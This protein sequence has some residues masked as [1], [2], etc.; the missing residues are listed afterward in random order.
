MIGK[1]LDRK[2]AK[3][4][5]I[6]K[7]SEKQRVAYNIISKDYDWVQ[8]KSFIGKL[9]FHNYRQVKKKL[10]NGSLLDIGTGNGDF[11]KIRGITN[12]PIKAFDVSDKMIEMAKKNIK[13]KVHFFRADLETISLKK[14]FDNIISINV[15]HRAEEKK[16]IKLVK[17]CSNKKTKIIIVTI[18]F[19]SPQFLVIRFI[20]KLF[21]IFGYNF[22]DHV[23]KKGYSDNDIKK[24]FKDF[25]VIKIENHG[26][27]HNFL[28]FEC[29]FFLDKIFSF[30]DEHLSKIPI[31]NLFGV[32]KLI[33]L[34]KY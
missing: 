5:K 20:Q 34:K 9:K 22:G 26:Y 23:L 14:K 6:K 4:H 12:R 10:V 19:Y 25:K 28:R 21:R 7:Q 31:I 30:L 1:T 2:M 18:N 15:L 11:F 8:N 13:K 32:C 3:L 17:N 27:F 29:G 24:N 33:V 16:F